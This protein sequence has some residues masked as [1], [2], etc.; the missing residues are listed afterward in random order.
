MKWVKE[1]E[2]LEKSY[3]NHSSENR[4]KVKYENLRTN[5]I[6]E[7]EKIYKFIDISISKED[8]Q[9]IVEKYSFENIPDRNKGP[10]KVTRSASP[11]KWKENFSEEEQTIMNKIMGDAL[12]RLGYN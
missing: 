9:K 3:E 8:L 10:G 11:G 6:T 2:I 4:I 7:L 12:K 1:M 5:T